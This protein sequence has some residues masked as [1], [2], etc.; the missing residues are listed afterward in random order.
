MI[1][2]EIVPSA[3]CCLLG[4][5]PDRCRKLGCGHRTR[6][7]S[8]AHQNVCGLLKA[9][10]VGRLPQLLL[11][12]AL[13]ASVASKGTELSIHGFDA[14]TYGQNRATPPPTYRRRSSQ[15]IASEI[16]LL[17]NPSPRT[18]CN[19]RNVGGSPSHCLPYGLPALSQTNSL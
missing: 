14:A 16:S 7:Q 10:A 2:A 13:P 6:P 5:K 11:I 12:K 15:W 4:H 18:W 9:V 19:S 17:L 1:G 3:P 8:A